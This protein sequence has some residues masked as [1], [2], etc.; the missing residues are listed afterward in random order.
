MN[1]KQGRFP[2]VCQG[3]AERY[4]GCHEKCEEYLTAKKEYADSLEAAAEY[5]KTENMM[6][7]YHMA[8]IKRQRKKKNRMSGRR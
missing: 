1:N 6:G 2:N 8:S 5:K 7:A 3:C 4:L